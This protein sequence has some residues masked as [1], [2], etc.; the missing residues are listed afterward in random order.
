MSEQREIVDY[1]KSRRS[2][3]AP[4]LAEPGPNAD[5]LAELLEI[6][7]RVPDHGMVVPWRLV[8]IAGDERA[9]AGEKLAQIAKSN[10]PSISEEMI[11]MERNRFL[12]AP[13]TI[14]VIS[15]AS[16]HP[17][18]PEL[19]QLLSA[20]CVCMNLVHGANALG[21]A[22][23]WVTRWFAFDKAATKMLGAKDNEQFVGFVH[24]GTSTITPQERARPAIADVVEYWSS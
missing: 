2:V 18:V 10:D 12:P 13:M 7:T 16:I 23:H 9:K 17:K 6:A 24:I 19:E 15:T 5:Q 21:F 20:G 8:I 1:L 22:A 3:T 11:E 14:G 4:F